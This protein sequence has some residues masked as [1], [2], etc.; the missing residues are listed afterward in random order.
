MLADMRRRM[1]VRLAAREVVAP[2]QWAY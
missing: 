2:R 1:I